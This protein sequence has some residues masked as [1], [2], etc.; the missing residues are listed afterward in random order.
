MAITY[1]EAAIQTIERLPDDASMNDII[2][3]VYARMKIERGLRDAEAGNLIDHEDIKR[4]IDEWL[5]SAG[6]R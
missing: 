5:R 4:E 6:R 3:A 1:K 2:Y